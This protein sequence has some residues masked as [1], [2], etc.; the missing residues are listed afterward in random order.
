MDATIL[1]VD[2]SRFA[3]LHLEQVL[4]RSGICRKM[5]FARNGA[6]ALDLLKAW[7]TGVP[8][9]L[10]TVHANSAEDALDRLDHLAQEAGLRS[11]A[12]L[13]A[14]TVDL[15]AFLVRTPAGRRVTE[16]VRVDGLEPDGS[17]AVTPCLEDSQ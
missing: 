9:G 16:I 12:R 13:V 17:Y 5:L 4:R 6:E 1:V 8:G 3:Q 11:A 2:D 15:V 14:C 7:N 10:A